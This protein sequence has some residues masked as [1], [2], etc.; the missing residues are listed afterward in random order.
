MRKS[1]LLAIS[2]LLMMQVLSLVSPIPSYAC[3]CVE[4]KAPKEALADATAVFAGQVQKIEKQTKYYKVTLAVN[5]AWKGVDSAETSVLTAIGGEASC[6]VE[7]KQGQ[8]YLIYTNQT[9]DGQNYASLC[10]RTKELTRADEDLKALGTGTEPGVTPPVQQTEKAIVPAA[11]EEPSKQ[12]ALLAFLE[13]GVW[14]VLTVLVL[15]GAAIW[16]IMR[17][18]RG[19]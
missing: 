7:F 15:G 10:S 14:V 19:N 3:S 16:M 6:G 11:Q 5:T 8:E 1:F 4:P 2:F 9:Q 12:N 13:K 18:K 17:R